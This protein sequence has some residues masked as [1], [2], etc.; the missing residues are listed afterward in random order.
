VLL[1][2]ADRKPLERRWVV[3]P[4]ILVVALLGGVAVH[5]SYT[6]LIPASRAAA[7]AV[8]TVVV[9]LSLIVGYRQSSPEQLP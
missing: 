2:T 9:L 5:A 7:T 8:I 3:L 1:L 6:G 4:T